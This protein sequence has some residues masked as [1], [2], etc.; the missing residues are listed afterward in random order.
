MTRSW[1]DVKADKARRDEA[2]GRDLDTARAEARTRTQAFVLGFRLA[3]LRQ[4]MRLSQGEVAHRMGISQPRVS[5]LESGDVGQME[6]DTLNRYVLALGGR[7][8]LVADFEDHDVN[9][10]TSEV[11]RAIV[12]QSD[13]VTS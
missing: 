12:Q 6:V 4:D 7:L 9:V 11:D 3:R 8:K 2:S 1:K 13:L 5:Q 10:S